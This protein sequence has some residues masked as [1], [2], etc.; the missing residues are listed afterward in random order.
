MDSKILSV[1]SPVSC[2]SS[3]MDSP[4]FLFLLAE[5][6]TRRLLWRVVVLLGSWYA[7][8]C[9]PAA[10]KFLSDGVSHPSGDCSAGA[11]AIELRAYLVHVIRRDNE[12]EHFGGSAGADRWSPSRA[13]LSLCWCG[14][15]LTPFLPLTRFCGL[16]Q[17][18]RRVS[19]GLLQAAHVLVFH[20]PVEHG[21]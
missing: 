10:L 4:R 9:A 1:V 18:A 3:V 20:A 19:P 2:V 12:I 21:R 17:I 16:P 15:V 14:H 7:T 11:Q 6:G 13:F 5:V 8:T